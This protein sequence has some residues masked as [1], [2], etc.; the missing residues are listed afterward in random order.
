MG[1]ELHLVVVMSDT[2]AAFAASAVSSLVQLEQMSLD[3]KPSLTEAA[4]TDVQKE[5]IQAI[6]A[7]VEQSSEGDEAK[8]SVKA[9][10]LLAGALDGEEAFAI[11]GPEF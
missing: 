5:N 7:L 8:S 11:G 9:H 1:R 4:T 6:L 2:A 3:R 10:H